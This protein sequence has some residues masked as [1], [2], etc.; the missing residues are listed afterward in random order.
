MNKIIATLAAATMLLTT[1]NAAFAAGS[2]RGKVGFALGVGVALGAGLALAASRATAA[3]SY[4]SGYRDNGYR[5]FDRPQQ[6][7]YGNMC[8]TLRQDCRD[9]FS[10]ACQKYAERC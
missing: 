2:N 1:Q 9:G 7:G 6:V 3:P 4:N 5:S 10:R 8:Q